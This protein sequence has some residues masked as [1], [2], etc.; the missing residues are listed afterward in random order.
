MRAYLRAALAGLV[1]AV[2]V[3]TPASAHSARWLTRISGTV[4]QGVEAGCLLMAYHNT[5]YVLVD[6]DPNVVKAG[7]HIT[8][9]GNP[10]PNE[11]TYC[12]QGGVVFHVAW[13]H[14]A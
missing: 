10:A 5:A 11:T 12:G 8:A 14:P 9:Y 4:V 2:L 7:A 13:A 6:G 1:L 3:V